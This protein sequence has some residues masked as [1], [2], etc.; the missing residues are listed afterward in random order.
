VSRFGKKIVGRLKNFVEK[1]PPRPPHSLTGDPVED[2]FWIALEFRVSGEFP[3]MAD[4]QLRHFWCDGF[5]PEQYL[6]DDLMPRIVGRAWIVD[7]QRQ[8]N[9]EFTLFLNQSYALRTDIDWFAL[10][11]ADNVTCWLALDLPGKRIQIEPVAAVPDFDPP[12]DT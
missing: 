11:P 2:E 12:T 3:G 6:L 10:L 7:D 5:I 4:K 1:F 8:E 9:W